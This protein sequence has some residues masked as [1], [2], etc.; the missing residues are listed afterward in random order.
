MYCFFFKLLRILPSICSE[1]LGHVDYYDFTFRN[2]SWSWNIKGLGC[3]ALKLIFDS[4]A[5]RF[6]N[7]MTSGLWEGLP[8]LEWITVVEK[9][10][11]RDGEGAAAKGFMVISLSGG[12]GLACRLHRGFVSAC[13]TACSEVLI[14][15]LRPRLR[16]WGA[17]LPIT[18]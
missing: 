16:C 8:V 11:P 18:L 15:L 1:H 14:W 17:L 9:L 2:I 13:Q 10:E 4:V 3:Q 6:L 5:L 12:G 7:L